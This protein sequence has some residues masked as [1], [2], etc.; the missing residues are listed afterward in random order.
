MNQRLAMVIGLSMVNGILAGAALASRRPAC[1]LV[2]AAAAGT[3]MNL[4]YLVAGRLWQ[5]RS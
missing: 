4:I 5:P 1:Y 2:I 3:F